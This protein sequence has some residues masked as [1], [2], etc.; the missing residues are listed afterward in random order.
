M[1]RRLDRL[2]LS[3][4]AQWNLPE[5]AALFTEK[6]PVAGASNGKGTFAMADGKIAGITADVSAAPLIVADKTISTVSLQATGDAQTT[7]VTA[8]KATVEDHTTLTATGSL[9]WAEPQPVSATWKRM[10]RNRAAPGMGRV[11]LEPTITAG[12]VTSKGS[13][14]GTLAAW[15]R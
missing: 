10:S 9:G 13:A 7:H 14:T 1:G 5:I 12:R 8:L 15:K 2:T 11:A 4:A 3:S 6:P